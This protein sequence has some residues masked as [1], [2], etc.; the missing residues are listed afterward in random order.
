VHYLPQPRRDQLQRQRAEWVNFNYQPGPSI[1]MPPIGNE[2]PLVRAFLLHLLKD[3]PNP[4]AYSHIF[5]SKWL[6]ALFAESKLL[7]GIGQPSDWAHL[8][9]PEHYRRILERIEL[10]FAPENPAYIQPGEDVSLQVD[11]KR[12]DNLL[13]KI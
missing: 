10:D 8:L 3:L 9:P 6:N 2:E 12:V 11:I 4:E 13:L 5:E 7:H 1:P